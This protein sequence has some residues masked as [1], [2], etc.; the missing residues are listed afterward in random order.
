MKLLSWNVAGL[1]GAIRKGFPRSVTSSVY[2]AVLFQETR[3]D[4]VP[5]GL[6]PRRWHA[7]LNPAEQKGYSGVLTLCRAEPWSVAHGMGD[8]RSDREG[9]VLTL[10]FSD[11]YLVNAYFPY[12]QRDLSRLGAKLEFD[13]AMA[14]WIRKLRRK[15]PVVLGGDFNVA[16]EER[17]IARPDSNRQ[18]AGFTQ[19]ERDW[20]TRFLR[21]GFVDSYRMFVHEG[22][23]YTWWTYRFHARERNIGWRI[24]YFLVAR[25]LAP[26]V[27]SATIFTNVLG[28][29]HAPVTIELADPS[30]QQS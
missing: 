23:H 9:R 3:T 16:H 20:F 21:T 17:D 26:R 6:V 1:R 27:R 22:G 10:E 12:A 11:F 13:R 14:R 29:D 15:K 18:S 4:S 25:E 8:P 19:E 2:S 24:D 5:E 30:R 28:S 7:Y